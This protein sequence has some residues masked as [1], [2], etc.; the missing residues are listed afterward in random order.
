[1]HKDRPEVL[2]RIQAR[3]GQIGAL[4]GQRPQLFPSLRC[5]SLVTTGLSQLQV[6]WGQG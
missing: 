1:M 4:Q 3:A 6:V 5:S 2:V